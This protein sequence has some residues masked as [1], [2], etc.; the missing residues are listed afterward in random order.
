MW[1][2]FF[3][4]IGKSGRKYSYLVERFK[5][6]SNQEEDMNRKKALL[7]IFEGYCEFEISTA[8][9]LLRNTHELFT[10]GLDN[11]PCK[12]EAGLTTIPDL[13]INEAFVDEYDLLIIPGGDLQPIAEA[14]ELFVWVEKFA[15]QGKVTAA[16]CSGVYVLA[17][18]NL[19]KDIPFTVTLT[20]E[21][22][23]HL[24][25]FQ[26]ENFH[27]QPIVVYD[28]I[29]TAQG[30][31]YVDF[32]IEINK[33]VRKVSGEAIDFYIGKRNVFMEEK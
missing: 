6:D 20:K 26:E 4:T 10:V 8:I 15:N 12:S 21:Q 11:K 24:G 32:G 5:E 23:G 30:H 9:S 31:A 22:R 7:L 16:I 19:L 27:Y 25:C 29:L 18:A 13:T 14:Q 28:N 17:K 33:M 2:A 3:C 1:L